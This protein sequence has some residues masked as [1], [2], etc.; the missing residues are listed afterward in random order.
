MAITDYYKHTATFKRFDNSLD[1]LGAPTNVSGNY[2][3]L[4]TNIKC[5]FRPMSSSEKI[6]RGKKSTDKMFMI[7]CQNLSIRESDIVI[8]DSI[9]YQITGFKNPNSLNH[10]KEIECLKID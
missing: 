8:I 7:Y 9:E 3:N 4:H 2:D 5:L 10:H 6:R 1:A